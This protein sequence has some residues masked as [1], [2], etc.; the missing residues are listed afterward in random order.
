MQVARLEQGDLLRLRLLH[1]HDHVALGKHGAG[2]GD[3]A[4]AD[5]DIIL[6]VEIDA[7]AGA[8]LD[9]HLMARGDQL[10]DGR[11]RQPDAIFVVLD[12]LRHADAHLRLHRYDL[13][14]GL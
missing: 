4:G 9:D 14:R 5:I 3:D 6:V 8:G 1:L 11:R 13:M 10:R 12:F 2:V 7:G